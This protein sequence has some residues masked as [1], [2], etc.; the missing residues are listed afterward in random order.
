LLW[1]GQTLF[2]SWRRPSYSILRAIV[3]K[4]K[5]L[6][7]D[8]GQFSISENVYCLMHSET[9]TSAIGNLLTYNLVLKLNWALRLQNG[10]NHSEFSSSRA[11][12]GCFFDHCGAQITDNYGCG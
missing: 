8:E 9:A 11:A 5:I 7:L 3:R 6:I 12:W 10:L 1:Q 2:F 4:S